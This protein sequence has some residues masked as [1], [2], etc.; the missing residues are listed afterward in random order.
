MKLFLAA[1]RL[2]YKQAAWRDP[3]QVGGLE[4]VEYHIEGQDAGPKHQV[5]EKVEVNKRTS[6]T[7][8]DK[9]EFPAVLLN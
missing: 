4:I 9:T 1:G 6:I 5:E 2:K 8:L 3:Y 7:D